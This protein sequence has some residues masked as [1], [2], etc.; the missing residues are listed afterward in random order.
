MAD[1]ELAT[2]LKFLRGDEAKLPADKSKGQVYFAYK[3]VGT[4]EKPSY[5][6]AIYMDAPIGGAQTRVKMTANA[7][8]ADKAINDSNGNS[9]LS[10]YLKSLGFTDDGKQIILIKGSGNNQTKIALPIASATK[11]GIV[12]TDAQT[13]GGT[14][15]FATV[16]ATNLN[17][18][19]ASSFNYSGI[20][21]GTAD[22]TSPVWF[23]DN[24]A[25]GKPVVNTNF[26]YNPATQTLTVANLA[27][28]ADKANK[29]AGGQDIRGTYIKSISIDK[30]IMTIMKGSG[31]T[32]TLSVRDKI[33][34]NDTVIST[35]DDL[36]AFLEANV[37][38]FGH[39]S[40]IE[41]LNGLEK[42]DGI[43]LS[44]A[45]HG[46]ANY[47]HQVYLDNNSYL[48]R[49]RYKNNTN[50][51]SSWAQILDSS[52]Y[53]T[54][55]VK[56]DGTGASGSWG[57]SITGNAATATKATNDAGGQD[58]RATYTKYKSIRFGATGDKVYLTESNGANGSTD[59]SS[60][61][62]IISGATA[63][64]AGVI[65]TGAQ[66]FAGNKI[67]NS[68]AQ[69]NDGI[70]GNSIDSAPNSRIILLSQQSSYIG[71]S[72]Y[73]DSVY[74]KALLK[75]I[76]QN[77]KNKENYTFIG[78]V[79]PN[80]AGYAS[81]YIYNT[82]NIDSTS[83]LPQCS[84]GTYTALNGSMYTFGTQQY[85]FYYRSVFMGD[86]KYA[87]STSVGGSANSAV[88]LDSSAGSSTQP[89]YFSAGKPVACTY[90]LSKSVPAD[91]KFTDT[92]TWRGIQNNLTS[93]ST[94]DSL[95]AAQGK[96]LNESK[97]TRDS[98]SAQVKCTIWSR[99]CKINYNTAAIGSTFILNIAGTRNS[100]V[101]NDTF[102]IKVHHPSRALITKLSGCN[103][104][105]I[106]LRVLA[107]SDGNCYVELKD[108]AHNA[109]SSTVQGVQ[110]VLLDWFKGSVEKYT[111]FTDG[112][113]L[114]SGF[115]VAATITTNANSL[116]GNLT[117][118]EITNKPSNFL[119][120]SGGTMTGVLGL[121]GN[122][123][124]DS[125]GT[126]ALNANNSDLF[127]VNSI[128]FADLSDSAAEG[129]QW[130]RDST[131]TDSFWVQNGVMYFTPNR[132]WGSTSATNYVV[133]HSGNYNSYAPGK[134][135]S[136]ASGN[137]NINVTGS[138]A[139]LEEI[140][141]TTAVPGDANTAYFSVYY[142]VNNGLANNMPSTNNANAIINICRHGASGDIKFNSQLGF[143]SDEN[144]YYRAGSG[145]KAWKKL[146]DSSNYSSYALPLSGGK[147]T[148]N[149]A[150][151]ESGLPQ[152]SGAPT[153]LLGID[154]FASGGATKWANVSTINVGSAT[155][156]QT[157]RTLWGQS[158]DGSKNIS[159]DISGATRI[160][161]TAG[162]SNNTLNLGNSANKGW[163]ATQDIRSDQG[164]DKWVIK[165]SGIA[166]F[167]N[168][169]IGYEYAKV[170][171]SY[172]LKI[173]G[174]SFYNGHVYFG[175]GTTY[176][177][178]SSAD[179]N[180]RAVGTGNNTYI[181]FPEGGGFRATTEKNTG[182]LKITLPHSWNNTMIRFK[183]SIYQ[184]Q[185]NTSCDYYVG[186][187]IY[188]GTSSWINTFAYSVGKN[189]TRTCSNLT[190]RFGH[191]GSK[192]AIYIGESTTL[193][194]YPQIQISDIVV[195]FMNYEYSSWATGWSIG[196]TT[197][198]GTITRTVSNPNVSYSAATLQ[199]N[200]GSSTK[201]VYF[202]GGI[203][204]QCN[205][206]IA[207]SISGKS[208]STDAINWVAGNEIRF[209]KPNYTE[210]KDLH[211][212]W[213][214][215]DGSKTK[216][217]NSYRFGGGDGNLT[218]VTASQFNG[219]L[220]G[221]ANTATALT[222][223]AG[224]STL[225]VY[226]SNGKPVACGTSLGVSIT[227][228]A[229]TAT[230]ADKLDG[231]H[232]SSDQAVNTYVLRNSSGYIYTNYINSNTSNGENPTISQII[233][234]NGSDGF[235]RKATLAHLKASLGSMPASDV[236]AW[237]KASTKPSYSWG[238]ITG[239]P[240]TFT[241]SSHTHDKIVRADHLD[242]VDKLN[243]FKESNTFKY[244]T[245]AALSGLSGLAPNDG[246]ILSM[247]WKD[248]TS[249][250]HQIFIDNSGY[251]IAHRYNGNNTW[252]SWSTIL[253]SSNYT[254]YT[255]TKTGSGAS[256]TWGISVTGSSAS[257]TGNAAT[258]TKLQTA[259]TIN[260]TSFDGSANITTANWGTAR[261]IAIRDCNSSN[262]GTAVSVN[263]S[264]AYYLL[265]PSSAR[266]TGTLG[267]GNSSGATLNFYTAASTIG[268]KI[269][270]YSDRIEFV[271]A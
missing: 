229:A 204:V 160:Y 202:S 271:F 53:T 138:A 260:G 3:N 166:G 100:V 118:G 199:T 42:N 13:F 9:I 206:T 195:G 263:G 190:V 8:I 37:F 72:N 155:K 188:G 239:K 173:Q 255:V 119:Y 245:V 114:P 164:T 33:Y 104:S 52:N 45:W 5:T 34:G 47:G 259:R 116:Q 224:S 174:N 111:S 216:L 210:A 162:D 238:E 186:G 225:P 226:F 205:D 262:T 97:L 78:R 159:G 108:S 232:G 252:S 122:Q 36:D 182:Y 4:A 29:D 63:N 115:T 92:N 18:T 233:V 80:S 231:Y 168:V 143:S 7:D 23:A 230:N 267:V 87:G 179:A 6:G 133:L 126:G 228:N 149:I 249:Y 17:V 25:N 172:A 43:I 127:N 96:L 211:I 219:A 102:L 1:N 254:S 58:I 135:G 158:F 120:T 123:C 153:Y 217:I 14:K 95:S 145:T 88:K 180:L 170:D 215:S 81:I 110:C 148:G 141:S 35:S 77:Y 117:W 70:M 103:Y 227:G 147:M 237:A 55:T 90:T 187:C 200:A 59:A 69:F 60:S 240:S 65:T 129:L 218:Q 41:G 93:T 214:W 22:A 74:F 31:A 38:K 112:T 39:I 177:I 203:P 46:N 32:S 221:N 243:A 167:K 191:D 109:T 30:N 163:V 132:T 247:S 91:A 27:G 270:A 189:D 139:S 185:D 85:A 71:D 253:D 154:S 169:N 10:T 250:G 192:C 20:G 94:T 130:Y 106:E 197:T 234:T 49:H 266:F 265:M 142:N 137:W 151:A 150:W 113:T 21:P 268:A 242:T 15:T 269:V 73:T 79:C 24:Y 264:Q 261:N 57:I 67:F 124:A 198:L 246:I 61:A 82:S 105:S 257:C 213:A 193:L 44:A 56:K 194:Y 223:S 196:F 146:L 51:W 207:N 48:L 128:K 241:P 11:A 236:Y 62:A 50:G 75:W 251:T 220:N 176:Y 76:C 144:V 208:A 28:T 184:Y 26:T 136:G 2:S 101:Y 98:W 66:T 131:H 212:G 16:N 258:A 235:Y 256:G 86:N 140:P 183:I 165:N 84:S 222:T 156:L 171:S 201:P 68:T 99:L 12:T 83:G 161:N 157:A 40:A 134:T 248:S 121:L 178:N 89:V 54:Y 175:N 64:A 181:A 244:A 152:F 19:G 107:D 125:Y 209:T